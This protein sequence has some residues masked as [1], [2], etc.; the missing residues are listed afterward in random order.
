MK[1]RSASRFLRHW[2]SK[3][4]PFGG[5]VV[6]ALHASGASVD[7]QAQDLRDRAKRFAIRLV[8]FVRTLPRDPA[9][10]AV[11]RQLIRS[12]TDASANYHAT[13][14]ARSRA[15]FVAKLGVVLEEADETVHWLDVLRFGELASG[16]ELEWLRNESRELRAVFNASVKTARANYSESL[17]SRKL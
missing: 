9:T 11:S 10:D 4:K 15:E 1:P 3:M 12:G 7:P 5:V 8:R 2:P 13:C 16:P 17:K 6:G 14:R